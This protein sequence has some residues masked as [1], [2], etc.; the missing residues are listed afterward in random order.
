MA[1]RRVRR[2]RTRAKSGSGPRV[3]GA[4]K[5][6]GP[7]ITVVNMIPKSLSGETNQ[8]SEPTI[9]VN[10]ANPLQIAG[11]A[12][13][14]APGGSSRGP[15]FVSSDGGAT[16][17]LNTIIPG[18][19]PLDI[20]M[21]FGAKS[22]LYAGILRGDYTKKDETRLNILRTDDVTSTNPMTI[23]KDRPGIGVDQPYVQVASTAAGKD[24]VFVGEN[25]GDRNDGRTAT[26]D[27]SLD[28]ATG[29][30]KFKMVSIESRGVQGSQDGPPVRPAIHSDGTVYAVYH[31]WR[32]FDGN[33]GDGTADIVVVRDD[34]GATGTAP[35][36]DLVDPND[37][38]VGMRVVRNT[39]FNFGAY[40]GLQRTGGDVSIAVDPTNSAR[41]YL[42][43]ND[44]Q[45]AHYVLHV[46]RSTDRGVTWSADVRTI[47]DALNP[48]LSINTD[49]T[50]GLLYQQLAGTG[51][52]QQWVSKVEMLKAGGSTWTSV[53]L[54]RT[55]AKSPVKQFDPYLG[56]YAHLMAMGKTF[57]GVFSASNVPLMANFPNG[58]TYQ[59]NAN[60]TSGKLLDVDNKTPV[61][62]SIDPFFFKITP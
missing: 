28:G 51:A 36:K 52:A 16:W 43:Y 25:Q 62:P 1:A 46:L 4:K 60:F 27:L 21:Q 26:I 10:P 61:D 6:A 44:D 40:L 22:R 42:A 30:G 8:D 9:A 24:R 7:S 35:F 49:G 5:T 59:R 3:H 41:V 58:V 15:L 11:S 47:Q 50:L 37:N 39:K 17:V 45:G 20:T 38:K 19:M 57:Y 14:P 31:S 18:T 54:A 55:A 48:S 29:T 33:S 2:S 13:T 34:H 23:L 56:D 32:T 12:F 53:V